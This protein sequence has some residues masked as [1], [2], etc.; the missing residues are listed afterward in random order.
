[1][2]S[3]KEIVLQSRMIERTG[4]MVLEIVTGVVRHISALAFP[5]AKLT[6]MMVIE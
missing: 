4:G 6:M 3:L 2:R 5:P 1:M